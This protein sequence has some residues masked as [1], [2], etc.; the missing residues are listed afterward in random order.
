VKN[1]HTHVYTMS[2]KH[3]TPD[4]FWRNFTGIALLSVILGAENLHLILN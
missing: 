3:W 1:T 2:Q 4:T